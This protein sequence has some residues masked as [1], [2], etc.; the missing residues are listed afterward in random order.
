[1]GRRAELI[2]VHK[3]QIVYKELRETLFWLKLIK[4]SEILNDDGLPQ[5]IVETK[6][7]SSIIAKSLITAKRNK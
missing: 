7:L 1:V 2:F 4:Q 3:L 5:M 6:Q